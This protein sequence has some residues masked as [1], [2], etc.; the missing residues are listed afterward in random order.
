MQFGS[1]T[2]NARLKIVSEFS[3][4]KGEDEN[5]DYLKEIYH[6]GYGFSKDNKDIAAWYSDEGIILSYG[7]TALN[8]KNQQ[9]ISWADAVKR[10]DEM[11]KEGI[12][13]TNVEIAEA[14]LNE[15]TLLAQELWNL[16][17]DLSEEANDA[18]YLSTLTNLSTFGYPDQSTE[19]SGK[20][21][22]AESLEEII[23]E[24]SKFVNDYQ[25]NRDL[26]RFHFHK[27][28]KL[29]NRLQEMLIQRQ[30]YKSDL[31]EINPLPS[32]ITDDEINECIKGGSGVSL[33]KQR[34]YK[35]F[36]SETSVKERIEFLKQEYGTGG[37]SPAVSGS[38]GSS[39]GHSAKGQE[40]SKKG[41]P[42]V[43]LSWNE[44]AKRIEALIEADRY[45]S[46]KDKEVLIKEKNNQES[47]IP[48]M[49]SYNE[50]KEN[51]PDSFVL[52]QVGAFY[53]AYGEDAKKVS[54]ILDLVLTAREIPDVGKVAMCGFPFF[55]SQRFIDKL[56]ENND[57]VLN[58]IPDG[59]YERETIHLLSTKKLHEQEE[60]VNKLSDEQINEINTLYNIL[61]SLKIEDIDLTFNESGLVAKDN[62]NIWENENF[63][64]F[65]IDE[66]F[67][68]DEDG[69]VNGVDEK[70][71]NEFIELTEKHNIRFPLLNRNEVITVE[72]TDVIPPENFRITDMEL[73]VGGAKTKFR[74]NMDA[75]N[76]LHE[77]EFD[78]RQATPDEQIILSKYVGWGG[79]ADAFD[80]NKDNWKDEYI[81]LV[82]A[83]SPDEY[84]EARASTLN[85]HYTSPV[86]I[87]AMYD[88]LKNMG[89]TTGNILEPA[90]GIG[91]FFGMLPDELSSSKLYGVELDSISGRIAKQLY[92]KA[93]IT[94]AGFETT[95]R[96]DFY[97]VAIGNVPFGQY[98][99]ND[100]AYNKLGFSIHDYFFAKS[101][102]QVR[103]GGVIAFI[104][105]RFTMD[106]KN[107]AV[108][109]YIA[110]RAD[111]LGAIRL[112]NN[113]FKANAG[114]DVVSDI[115][116]LQKKDTPFVEEPEWVN[117]VPN[118]DGFDINSYFVEHPEMILGNESSASTQYGRDDFTVTPFEDVPL[119]ELLQNA[120]PNIRGTYKETDIS[121]IEEVTD[122]VLPAD[123]NVRNYSFTTVDGNVYFRENSIMYQPEISESNIERIKGMIKLRD[124]VRN[125]I[126]MQMDGSTPDE[127]I[128]ASQEQLNAIYDSFV[129]K[130]GIINSKQNAKA[131]S[132]DDSYFLLCSL[133]VVD[134]DKN[135]ERKSDFFFKRTINPQRTVT[136]V[137]TSAEALALSIS[138]RACVDIEY[139]S[140]LCGKT[141]DEIE[142]DLTGVI[143]RDIKEDA[144]E[145]LSSF[146]LEKCSFVTV[147]EYLSGNIRKKL[148][149][150]EAVTESFPE[151]LPIVTSNIESLKQVLPS[152]LD[153]SE[154]E[155]RLGA[156]WIDKS[157]VEQ[158]MYETFKTPPYSKWTT[159]VSYAPFTAE[160]NISG[161]SNFG[162]YDV[163]ATST[164][165]TTRA[166]A[167][168]I[169]ED[170]INL[171]DVRVYDTIQDSDGKE[172]R[173][174]NSKETTLAQQ[175]QQI[176]K[177]EF[178][179]WIWKDPQ[180]RYELVN[181]YNETFNSS[182]PRE[183][184]GK[185]LSFVGMN[186]EIRLREHQLNAVAHILYGGNTLL[187]H[188]VGTGKTFEMVAAAMEAKRLGLCNKPLFV[189][190]NHLTEQWASEFL[191]LYP[192]ANILV[193]KKKDF[194]TQNR[195]K[196]C[197]RIATGDYDAVIIGH[198][199]FEKI[200]V[201][202]ERQRSELENQ[203]QEIV[204]GI[205]DLRW[206]R[207]NK[208]TVKQLE[209]TKR[210]L[211]TKLEKLMSTERKDDVVTFEQL[212]V[213]RLFVDEAHNYKNL[214]LY[215]KMRNV[216]GIST[217]E[218]QKSSDMYM[219][220]RYMD[221]ITGNKGI[222]FATGTPVSNSMTEL[223][224]MMRYLQNST[225]KER[226]LSHFDCWAS[227]FGETSTAIELAPEGTGYRARTRFSKF[228]NLP[229][230][231]SLFK[232]C[233]D[234][235]TQDQL[236]LPRPEAIYHNEVAEP[237][238]I[239]KGLVKELSER[240]AAILNGAVDASTDNMLKITSD[241]RKLGLDQRIINPEF[242]DEPSTKVNQ[243]V[244]NILKHYIEGEKDKLTQLVFCDISTPKGKSSKKAETEN[245]KKDFTVYEDIRDK[246]IQNGIKAEEIAF[247]HDYDTDI[248]KKDLFAKV[249]SG[250]IRVLFGSTSKMGAGMNVQDRL[251]A[252]HDLDAP[253]RPGDLE[254]RSGRIIRQGNKNS[255]VHIYRY[256]TES[257]FDAYLWQTLEQKQKFIS[258]IMTS[259]SPVR[260]C[261]DIDETALSF[262]E[263]KALCAG[264]PRI[265]E[266]MDLD[267]DVAKLKLMRASHQSQQFR[268]EDQLLKE[269][270]EQIKTYKGYIEGFKADI[271]TLAE[272]PITEDE[273]V[274]MEIRG[275]VL[276]DKENAG[277][278]LIDSFKDM[279]LFKSV[280]VGHYRGFEMLLSIEDFGKKKMLTLKGNMSHKVE[281]GND[282]KGNL[283]RIENALNGIPEKLT[284]A[285]GKLENIYEQVKSAEA[286]KGKPFP[287]EEEYQEKCARLNALNI[288]LNLD[289]TSEP[290]AVIDD[291]AIAK[292]ARPS[293]LA[294]VEENKQKITKPNTHSKENSV[295]L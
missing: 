252:L 270:P 69:S 253:W 67:V 72:P 90:M 266:K 246:L 93:D 181:L 188:E 4:G 217:T 37:G 54:D 124:S 184:D 232:E 247:I 248:K 235:K 146:K 6:G 137:D 221:E 75:I 289:K 53:E 144:A 113:A 2:D 51:N 112:P 87:N 88:A 233:A 236:N 220:C 102:D 1:N 280:S 204:A 281:L 8:S 32:F 269:F 40:L 163:M 142:K 151:T 167:Y 277:A 193:A 79:L 18:G 41:C 291:E 249:R 203:I 128:K 125:L 134:E 207:E 240:A 226:G 130:H 267:V 272:H 215:T 92:P 219:K 131:F 239:Q 119:S 214:Y 195:K 97:D 107:P 274:G 228:F 138:E 199:Q 189:V 17:V 147:D 255:Q 156:T 106:S 171:R 111:L 89:Y 26:L 287:R 227:T 155:V 43:Q 33:G 172:R 143:F 120:I 211:E 241:G 190:P 20:I 177:D 9:T 38:S 150:A 225:L 85:A 57:V 100:R 261:D 66:V 5:A 96:K 133:E 58:A 10:I 243:C 170:T 198:S 160:W 64:R 179:N 191:R 108:R 290:E 187:A 231:M 224:T 222:V 42:K 206:S 262:A 244:N 210:N 264:D 44:V 52:V 185:H 268:L 161:K 174:L 84:E 286:E 15:R 47:A 173:V 127:D 71:L 180:R 159:K 202:F 14:P 103:P 86:V 259:K 59:K 63:Y 208:F 284:T 245:E 65:L 197:A 182:R 61:L 154:I 22:N 101:L 275:D 230:L 194:D 196:F 73:G 283:I 23:S 99:V 27:P 7:N 110:E 238:E 234:I 132:S 223:Y 46:P 282:P 237:T 30:E 62:D 285:E 55:S 278:A 250:K 29:L 45:L 50:I 192:S 129:K 121:E 94:V 251:I 91:N 186:P 12:F 77:L 162:K 200:P 279:T 82:T 176:I 271:Q 218:A 116:F 25:S 216:A 149:A 31:S 205:E 169:L 78:Q 295:E 115:I 24:L 98:K 152:E 209:K 49:E 139:M 157:Y 201:S 3:K 294:K 265:K 254:Q 263:I 260:S 118:K 16:K 183:Y 212:G 11:L 48:T 81:E 126:E 145:K 213:D 21:N 258:Q 122:N 105:S 242:A 60:P 80:E 153:A 229:E 140:A 136:S 165:G 293:L 19:I 141:P 13:A 178:Q 104:T 35:F 36:I 158:F 288:E 117:L 28:E 95:S 168:K 114:T 76:L 273:F 257:T 292:S 34:I 135:F 70:T 39:E 68:Y 276:T 148:E 164:F 74:M 83:L 166:N 175:K 109:K 123:P 56:L 256:V